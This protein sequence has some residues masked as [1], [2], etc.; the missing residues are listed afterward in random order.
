VYVPASQAYSPRTRLFVRS[1]LSPAALVPAMSGAIRGLDPSLPLT[2]VRTMDE[3]IGD[4]MWRTRVASWLLSAFAG[5]ALLLTAIGVFGVMS[6]TV[7]QRVHEIGVRMALGAARRD[8]MR[9]V[10]GR[11][12]F[13]AAAGIAIGI[14]LALAVT[15][16]MTALLYGVEPTDPSTIAI[17]S[18]TLGV[19]AFVASYL[20]A[21]RAARV[22]PLV[23]LRYE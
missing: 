22:D 21:R 12:S 10:L 7:T 13:V 9:L 4:A 6:Q 17:V 3:R 2:E 14:G 18:L 20:P 5:L 15:R 16:V 8:V 19:V 11:T 1:S 23:A